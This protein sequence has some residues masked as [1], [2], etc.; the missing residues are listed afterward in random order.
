METNETP[1][2]G[3]PA[4]GQ[5]KKRPSKADEA[6]SIRQAITDTEANIETAR[7]LRAQ[8][9]RVIREGVK[10]VAD[11]KTKLINLLSK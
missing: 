5:A 10:V 1:A 9:E 3:T 8:N 6:A 11:L 7:Q 4:N 2:E